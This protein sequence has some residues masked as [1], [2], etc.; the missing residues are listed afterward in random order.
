MAKHK[1]E[2]KTV[3][4]AV[5]LLDIKEDGRTVLIIDKIEYDFNDIVKQSLGM[6]V[7]FTSTSIEE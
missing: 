4:D 6:E 3:I 1:Y 2:K 7:H 5:G